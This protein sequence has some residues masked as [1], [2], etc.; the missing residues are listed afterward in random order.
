MARRITAIAAATVWGWDRIKLPVLVLMAALWLVL[1]WAA[2]VSVQ[3]VPRYQFTS[4]QDYR[5]DLGRPTT[6]DGFV[7]VNVHTVNIRR[8]AN[9]SLRPP[10]YGVFSGVI[11]TEPSNRLFP[12]PVNPHFHRPVEMENPNV[13]PRFDTLQ[14]GVNAEPIGNPINM[15]NVGQTGRMGEQHPQGATSP[16]TLPNTSVSGSDVVPHGANN[17]TG[18]WFERD[19]TVFNQS[20]SGSSTV[21]APSPGGFLLPTTVR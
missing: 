10:G 14:M 20:G 9:V 15:F 6:F 5:F 4:G 1:V 19:G 8:D 21:T 13:I 18:S 11:P 2:Q 3:A 12:R 17:M 16:G 7:P